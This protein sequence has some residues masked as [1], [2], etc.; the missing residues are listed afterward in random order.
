M[1][2]AVLLVLTGCSWRPCLLLSIALAMICWG[3][4]G[5]VREDNRQAAAHR[6][7]IAWGWAYFDRGLAP[8]IMLRSLAKTAI[9]PPPASSEPGS[10][11]PGRLPWAS[12]WP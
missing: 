2:G 10:R 3:V 6:P 12:F 1:N 8:I 5:P 9:G 7:F 4:Y 11:A